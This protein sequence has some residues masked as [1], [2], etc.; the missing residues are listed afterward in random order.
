MS[1]DAEE[2]RSVVIDAGSGTVCA[3]FSGDDA[4]RAVFTS[5][6]GKPRQQVGAHTL[7]SQLDT[8]FGSLNNHIYKI[9]PCF[10]REHLPKYPRALVFEG[11]SFLV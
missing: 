3:G 8:Y 9:V 1:G 10:E 6:I 5:V 4:P 11:C 7:H 2:V